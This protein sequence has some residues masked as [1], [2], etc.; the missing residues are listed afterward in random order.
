MTLEHKMKKK[1]KKKTIAR[2]KKKKRSIVQRWIIEQR[3]N[4]IIWGKVMMELNWLMQLDI[5]T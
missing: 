5:L 4:C 1:Q 2:K 3:G